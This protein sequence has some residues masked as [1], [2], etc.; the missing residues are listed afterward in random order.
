M[1]FDVK[2]GGNFCRKAQLMAGGHTTEA[3]ATLTYSLFVSRDSVRIAL[4]IVTLNGL[5]VMAYDIQN[6]Y[7]TAD[8]CEKIW[9]RSGPEFGSEAGRIMFIHKVLY[10]LRSS[11]A[12]FRA[13]L[14]ETLYDF[15]LTRPKPT[16]MFGIG[17]LSNRTAS[18]TMSM[19]C[20]M[21]M[22]SSP[23]AIKQKTCSRQYKPYSS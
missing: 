1:I 17:Q 23:L 6:A 4:T 15:D 18:N 22:T 19:S 20:V 16:Q 3:P 12:A 9:T 13:H 5:Q 11:G 7:L 8:C 2:I 21:L 14:G 10:D